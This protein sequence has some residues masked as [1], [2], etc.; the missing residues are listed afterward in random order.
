MKKQTAESA[1]VDTP[2]N[3]DTTGALVILAGADPVAMVEALVTLLASLD[4]EQC[5]VV[6]VAYGPVWPAVIGMTDG[7]VTPDG[8]TITAISAFEDA[9]TET[10]VSFA[11]QGMAGN[12]GL[13]PVVALLSQDARPQRGWLT[14]M[15]ATLTP[16]DLRDGGSAV[17]YGAVGIVG[18]STD[19]VAAGRS[20]RLD[21][22]EEE[23]ALGPVDYAAVRLEHFRGSVGAADMIDPFC[24]VLDREAVRALVADNEDGM[25]LD[26]TC[27]EWAGAD[28][29]VR[30]A[31]LGWRCAVAEA[32]F[33]A[34]TTPAPDPRSQP[35]T[36][37]GRLR[38]YRKHTPPV[39]QQLA[40]GYRVGLTRIQDLQLLRV[41]IARAARLA[42][43]IVVVLRN[44]PLDMQNDPEFA[45]VAKAKRL[46]ETDKRLFKACDGA[47]PLAVSVAMG[48]WLSKIAGR[49]AP[50][51]IRVQCSTWLDKTDDM[52]ERNRAIDLAEEMGAH[53][54]L[55]LNQDEV[56]EER[57]TRGLIDRL[58]AHPNPLVQCWDASFVHHWDS[59]LLVR[60]DAPWGDGGDWTGGQH[61]AR[62]W[63]VQRRV[64]L[65]DQASPAHGLEAVRVASMRFRR[66]WT[67][68]PDDR[69]T[70]LAHVVEDGMRMAAWRHDNGVGL[71]V[72]LYERE[73]PE[74][75]ARWLD[76]VHGLVDHVVLVWTGDWT[77]DDKGWLSLAKLP[78]E[79]PSTGPTMEMAAVAGYH[80][81][82]WI[83]QPL[84][85]NLATARNAGIE[86]LHK[87]PGLR[88]AWFIDPDEWFMDSLND[89]RAIRRMA[90][91]DRWGWLV[92]TANY[93]GDGKVP[94]VSDSVRMSRLDPAGI[95]RMDGRVHESFSK[96]T[97]A[98]QR[99]GEHPR[100]VYAPFVVQHRGMAFA[101]ARMAEKLGQYERLL[102]LE[103][104]DNP[105]SPGAWVSLGWHYANDGH[106]DLAVECYWRGIQCAGQSYLPFKELG[107][108]HL[109][110][111]R[112]LLEAS[113]D[114]LSPAHQFH[115]LGSKLVK[116]LQVHAPPHPVLGRPDTSEPAPLP[117][118]PEPAEDGTS[119]YDTP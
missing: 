55:W 85:D 27:G 81:A 76:C 80:T 52:G 98:I 23:I 72:L 66:F 105:H 35:D 112:R 2:T 118:F 119:G 32:V 8:V 61:A 86:E 73:H 4:G 59:P 36:A 83:H 111:A 1:T 44:N 15:I 39:G 22:A 57:I 113:M 9:T 5:R 33:V 46:S 21:L 104:E 100:F 41:S 24:M 6:P 82:T 51:S 92:Q 75:L 45:V 49:T 3:D 28:L 116:L 67:A 69:R 17:A 101:D 106:A 40:V 60:E 102:R 53:W 7:I 14:E 25:L 115:P 19:G 11:V 89:S 70:R 30:A 90:E 63:R 103:L 93:R 64:G 79:W 62:L 107:Y 34:R 18:P 99:G 58:M 68:R 84:D 94:S 16:T 87:A 47:D 97:H 71:H 37:V 117:D 10:A 109:R 74:D 31:K 29:C 95:M 77:D 96:A 91:S 38:F 48:E 78:D 43:S 12:H 56:I 42:D 65:P 114:R 54:L 108:H 88:W 13:P 50:G 110:E 26:P 20:Q